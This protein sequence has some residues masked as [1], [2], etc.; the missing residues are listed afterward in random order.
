MFTI[1]SISMQKQTLKFVI[2]E[3]NERYKNQIKANGLQHQIIIKQL[4][5]YLNGEDYKI[6]DEI[7]TALYYMPLSTLALK[8]GQLEAITEAI[9]YKKLDLDLFK[10][11]PI[12]N[13]TGKCTWC[14]FN[15]C[16]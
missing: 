12:E 7:S 9:K 15:I 3:E 11:L 13:I 6:P 1:M 5:M 16:P 10:A 14:D 2:L 8:R 4:L